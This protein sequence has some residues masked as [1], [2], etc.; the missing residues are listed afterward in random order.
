MNFW[1]K[2]IRNRRAQMTNWIIGITIA[3]TIAAALLPTAI[4][5]ITDA[6]N[7]TGAPS[8]VL[9]MV[10]IIGIAVIAALV[11]RFFKGR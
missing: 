2:W 8:A 9:T 4:V 5:G 10:P 7:W 6:D 3:L 1:K 11:L